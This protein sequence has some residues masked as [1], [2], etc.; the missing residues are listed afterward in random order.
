MSVKLIVDQGPTERK[1]DETGL[2]GGFEINFQKTL[3]TC[4]HDIALVSF[5]PTVK[6]TSVLKPRPG[7]GKMPRPQGRG[8]QGL[9]PQPDGCFPAPDLRDVR[10]VRDV[11]QLILTDFYHPQVSAEFDSV[12]DHMDKTIR[13]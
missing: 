4:Y 5:L 3:I 2:S 6:G 11:R 8:V 9:A 7:P 1:H 13:A 12:P 10:D